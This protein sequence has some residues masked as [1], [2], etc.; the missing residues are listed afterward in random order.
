MCVCVGGMHSQNHCYTKWGFPQQRSQA[1]NKS[2][3]T[4]LHGSGSQTPNISCQTPNISCQTPNISCQTPNISCQTP[5]FRSQTPKFRSQSSRQSGAI[6]PKFSKVSE[7]TWGARNRSNLL[8]PSIIPPAHRC[9]CGVCAQWGPPP[10]DPP[11]ARP[12]VPPPTGGGVPGMRKID[13][14]SWVLIRP[15]SA[16]F[17]P[18]NGREMAICPTKKTDF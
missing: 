13:I 4:S 8:I 10:F 6:F 17:G 9:T 15:F 11:L 5:D 12:H 2:C 14:Q 7:S 3:Q 16:S 1:P 18:R